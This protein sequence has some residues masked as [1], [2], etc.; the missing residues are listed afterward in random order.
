MAR[1]TVPLD[2]NAFL[3]KAK[4]KGDGRNYTD[5][6]CNLRIIL[7]VAHKNCILEASLGAWPAEG[8]TPDVMNVWQTKA[9]DYSIVQCAMLYGLESGLQNCFERHGA[10]EMFQEAEM[11]FQTHA[12]VKRYETSDKYFAYKMEENSSVSEHALRMSRYYNRLNQV[13]VNL[14]NKIVIG[15]V[16]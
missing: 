2:F 11:I 7:I 3:E 8:E 5:W 6:V 1:A 12:R 9:D 13:G 10:Y 16:L 4:L 15:R 14:P